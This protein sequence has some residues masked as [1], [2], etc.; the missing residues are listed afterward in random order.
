VEI[1]VERRPGQVLFAH[2]T[3]WTEDTAIAAD[4]TTL[5]AQRV[6]AP[7]ATQLVFDADS[8]Q[9]GPGPADERSAEVLGEVIAT[10]T[11]L[12]VEDRAL[13]DEEGLLA[14]ARAAGLPAPARRERAWA[15]GP[16]ASNRFV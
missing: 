5:L 4:V 16:V 12:P 1:L 7:W 11:A 13:D 3:G 9:A 8:Q 15:G 10:A 14:L 6:V 2:V